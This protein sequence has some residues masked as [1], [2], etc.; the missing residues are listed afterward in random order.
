MEIFFF[1]KTGNSHITCARCICR[2]SIKR[3]QVNMSQIDLADFV[4]CVCVC[5]CVCLHSLSPGNRKR[6]D[7]VG[8]GS[9]AGS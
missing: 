8:M 1:S 5:M 4:E 9:Q 6:L 2:Y 3:I 7:E